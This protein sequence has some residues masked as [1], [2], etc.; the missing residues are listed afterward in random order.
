MTARFGRLYRR[1]AQRHLA[2]S[3]R[4]PLLQD[5]GGR[6]LGRVE[7]VSLSEGRLIVEGQA[8]A[9]L[10]TL[11]L[12]GRRNAVHPRVRGGDCRRSASICP[13]CPAKPSSISPSGR[14]AAASPCPRL[15][16][17]AWP[18]PGSCFCPA[19]SGAP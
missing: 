15:R 8:Q 5:A 7:R 19:S 14:R 1:Y 13:S 4:G 11:E 6:P 17:R 12:G 16:P 9:D 2:I 18:W 3:L 10:V